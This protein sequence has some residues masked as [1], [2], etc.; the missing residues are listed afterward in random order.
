MRQSF[1]KP[2]LRTFDYY[3]AGFDVKLSSCL[4]PPKGNFVWPAE[5]AHQP[6][7]QYRQCTEILNT[8]CPNHYCLFIS[9]SHSWVIPQTDTHTRKSCE[10][11][12]LVNTLGENMMAGFFHSTGLGSC[13]EGVQRWLARV[14]EAL[15]CCTAQGVVISSSAIMLVTGSDLYPSCQVPPFCHGYISLTSPSLCFSIFLK[16]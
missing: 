3:L 5:Q 6:Y 4:L 12:N 8:S 1:W 11:V 10:I 16:G 13:Q 2:L 15:K 9:V 7:I 14:A